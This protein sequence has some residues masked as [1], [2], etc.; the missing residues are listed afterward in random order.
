MRLPSKYSSSSRRTSSSRAGLS[1][2]RGLS[3]RGELVED[4]V[5][6]AVEVLVGEAHEA[7]RRG[8]GDERAD[9]RVDDGVGDVG[10]GAR[11]EARGGGRDGVGVDRGW[12]ESGGHGV[13]LI[14]VAQLLEA[15]VGRAP[16]RLL[17]S[18]PARRR[19]RRG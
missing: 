6:A 15:L 8:G 17:V 5:E 13:G 2:I 14:S 18:S 12:V 16:G 11:G 9:G 1:R 19:P 10:L 4:G 7:L 3:L